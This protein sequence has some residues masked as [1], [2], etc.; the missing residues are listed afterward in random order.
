MCWWGVGGGAYPQT[1]LQRHALH[2]AYTYYHQTF[3]HFAQIIICFAASAIMRNACTIL[4]AW[5]KCFCH[6]D[7]LF[8]FPNRSLPQSP[9]SQRGQKPSAATRLSPAESSRGKCTHQK[10]QEVPLRAIQQ[11]CNVCVMCVYVSACGACVCMVYM[12]AR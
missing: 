8:S 5:L 1:S 4:C 10:A 11:V 7:S 12:S 9:L 3:Q 2:A 6:P